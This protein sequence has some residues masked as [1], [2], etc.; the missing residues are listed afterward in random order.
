MTLPGGPSRAR[1]ALDHLR[2]WH[3][4]RATGTLALEIGDRQRRLHLVDG[5]LQLPASNALAARVRDLPA[6][7]AGVRASWL[8]LL[9]RIADSLEEGGV[10]FAE[11]RPGL[12]DVPVEPGAVLPTS[13]LIRTGYARRDRRSGGGAAEAS[14][15]SAT[16]VDT[17]PPDALGWSPEELWVLERL[18]APMAFE[19]LARDCP[20]AAGRLSEALAG[21]I[22]VERV[23]AP[24][25]ES[26]AGGV[27]IGELARRFAERI[28]AEL[29]ERPLEAAPEEYRRKV[30]DLLARAGALGHDELLGV[31]PG[32]DAEA[33][34]EAFERIARWVHPSNAARFGIADRAEALRFLFERATE[35]YRVLTDPDLRLAYLAT[36]AVEL[37][38]PEQ[39][40]GA[41][42][43]EARQ[44]ARRLYARAVSE[45][46]N[47]DYHVALQLLEQAVHTDGRAEYWS[48]LGRLQAR[49][50][51]WTGRAIESLKHA[52]ELDPQSGDVRYALGQLH[53]RAG[54]LERARGQYQAAA[55]A[56]PP[57]AG[58]R[59]ALVR[60]GGSRGEGG[61]LA[62]LFRR[63]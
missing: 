61:A 9:D 40:P 34:Q 46:S 49:N 50:P 19:E 29:A 7:A 41:R 4:R 52:L 28:G 11:F 17:A 22:A 54:D 24:A 16:G 59:E 47:G 31:A 30:A 62:R 14:R 25:P 51:A 2:H 33:V 10:R 1:S 6:P 20:F 36:R 56:R 55:A 18:R 3:L 39:D 21:L 35:A 60:L 8:E 58:A 48:A 27:E 45:E 38:A 26:A 57:H 12:G 37:A 32:A 42:L 63:E 43:T 53:E 23:H 13:A 15:W 5:Q 44:E